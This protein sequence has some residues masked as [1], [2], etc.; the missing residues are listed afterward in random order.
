M[1]RQV[2]LNMK[3]G[4]VDIPVH[5]QEGFLSPILEWLRDQGNQEAADA[6][7]GFLLYQIPDS[8]HKC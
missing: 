7:V 6:D 1:S 8:L 3:D 5:L 2:I 4:R